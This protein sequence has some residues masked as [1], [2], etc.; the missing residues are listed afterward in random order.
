MGRSIKS[1]FPTSAYDKNKDKQNQISKNQKKENKKELIQKI[2]EKNAAPNKDNNYKESTRNSSDTKY[3]DLYRESKKETKRLERELLKRDDEINQIK[4]VSVSKDKEIAELKKKVYELRIEN[5]RLIENYSLLEEQKKDHEYELTQDVQRLSL[6]LEQVN[7]N[8]K[9]KE[10]IEK[11]YENVKRSNENSLKKMEKQR[12]TIEQKDNEC[13]NLRRR[14]ARAEEELE[15][16]REISRSYENLSPAFLLHSL[17][18]SI[19]ISNYK[20][21]SLAHDLDRKLTRIERG[22]RNVYRTNHTVNDIT[23]ELYGNVYSKGEEYVFVDI[24]GIEYKVY[25]M[26]HYDGFTE[27]TPATAYIVSDK[28]VVVSYFYKKYSKEFSVESEISRS[29][30]NIRNKSNPQRKEDSYI[31]GDFNVLIVSA[32]DGIKYRDRLR[33]HGLDAH[34]VDGFEIKSRTLDLMKKADIVIICVGSVT[35]VYSDYAKQ[36]DDPK[37]QIIFNANEEKIVSRVI[38]AK[39]ILGL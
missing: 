29:V 37:Y 33:L 25:S 38:Y 13:N 8:L 14:L 34:L 17:I 3:K 5:E 30:K 1:K 31:I 18:E 32:H 22:I 6:E 9:G 26:P 36:Q 23:S 24:E 15:S 20:E 21:F 27:G 10:Y 16:L 39:H 2:K 4:V 35:H 7:A 28:D 19:D 12:K 11:R